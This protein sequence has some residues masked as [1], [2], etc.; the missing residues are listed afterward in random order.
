MRETSRIRLCCAFLIAVISAVG[1]PSTAQA[2]T[3][4]GGVLSSDTTWTTSGSPYLITSTVQ[5][6]EGVTL[7]I[8]PGVEVEASLGLTDMFLVHGTVSAIGQ[9]SSRI[10]FDGA[11]SANFFSPKSSPGSM[12]VHVEY[13]DIHDGK[14]L[15][16]PSGHEQYGH[17]VLRHSAVSNLTYYSYIWYPQQDVFIEYNTFVNSLGFSIGHGA[18]DASNVKVYVRWNRFV[19][20]GEGFSAYPAWIANWVSYG[21]SKT[22]VN[23]N[24]FGSMPAGKYVLYLPPGYPDTAMDGTG[25]YWGTTDTSVIESLIYDKNDDITTASVIPYSPALSAAPSEVPAEPKNAL[26][27]SK[28]GTGSGTV[29]SQPSGIDCGNTCTADFG[30][31]ETVTLAATPAPGSEFVG[32]SGACSGSSGCSMAMDVAR[33]VSAQFDVEHFEHA[34]SLTLVLR[35]HLVAKGQLISEGPSS[36]VAGAPVKIQKRASGN[37]KLLK[38]TVTTDSGSYKV[39]LRDKPGRYRAVVGVS[40][41][42]A[43]N[44][45]L[46]ARSAPVRHRH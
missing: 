37:W 7:T 6:P 8:E 28:S 18:G 44:T 23:G 3:S 24:A 12:L 1:F 13:A 27:V 21:N 40:T 34:R 9:S 2:G 29:T 22:V 16:P 15:W 26:A 41:L 46:G 31:S 42:D 17:L 25:N 20:F 43:Q 14:S 5:V 38:S 11:G 45:C 10:S 30:I 39:G 36:C 4:V 33:N 19:S 32:W 35:R